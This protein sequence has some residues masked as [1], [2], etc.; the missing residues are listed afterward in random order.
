MDS[1]AE[2]TQRS[3]EAGSEEAEILEEPEDSQIASDAEVQV[4][5]SSRLVSR[6]M[7]SLPDEEIQ[8]RR[9]RD[10]R[11]KP[12]VPPPVEDVAGDQ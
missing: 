11:Q 4:P 7:D 2:G 1:Q 12:S 9:D 5:P 6:P 3:F 8:K 10:Q